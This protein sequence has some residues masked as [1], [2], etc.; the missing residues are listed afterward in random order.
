MTEFK[1]RPDVDGLRAVAVMLVLLFHG[2]LGVSGGFV[3]VDVFFVISGFLITG[4]ILKEQ[5]NGA[6]RI[7]QFWMRRIRRILPASMMIVGATLIA[8]YFILLPD[9]FEE[10]GKSA[11]AQQL[12]L[13]NVFFWRTTSYFGGA[14]E[15]KP[16]LHTWSLAVE[17]QFYLGYPFLLMFLSRFRRR[18]VFLALATLTVG[19][20]AVS[21][22]GSHARPAPT[23][24]L[25]PTRAWELLA[26]GLICFVP[27][28]FKPA[29]RIASTLGL[30]GM[31][32]I[33]YSAFS[34]DHITP[35]PGANALWPCGGA[36]LLIL[37]S[38]SE[39]SL[40]GRLL[41]AR[42]VVFVGLISYSLYLWHW[43]ILVYLKHLSGGE[44][45]GAVTSLLALVASGALATFSLWFIETPFRRRTIF[46]DS[47][48]LLIG[49]FS[50]ATVLMV[51]S[52]SIIAG[53]GAPGRFDAV[54]LSYAAAKYSRSALF[55]V[56]TAMV[57]EGQ[58]PTCG[59]SN[60]QVKCLIWGD[61]HA[62]AF[63]PGLEAACKDCKIQCLQAT[64]SLTP[65]IL[66]FV[67]SPKYG[68]GVH[69]PEFSRAVVEFAKSQKVSLVVLAACW[70]IY[71]D[72]PEFEK[73]LALT[74]QE[75]IAAGMQ[76]VIV[77]EVCDQKCNVPLKLS[78][79]A[80]WHQDVSKFGVPN[81]EHVASV[82]R[83]TEV[84]R[85]LDSV[86]GDH[87]SLLDPTPF[88][89][90][91]TDLWRSEFNGIPMYR[92]DHHLSVEGSLRLQPLFAGA[93]DDLKRQL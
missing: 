69:S 21:A 85:R 3:G 40:V 56:T 24:F 89:V 47:R 91:E 23:F 75:L 30:L 41:A 2:G 27:D 8:G 68:L 88:L 49:T 45:L 18:T 31:G 72:V 38:S 12:M 43:P 44:S 71:A 81:S 14:A 42:P 50:M 9:D 51:A 67:S 84:F 15:L 10:L 90:D 64:H 5:G 26:G 33:L 32:G 62:M 6:F 34:F 29:G 79:A 11:I 48:R 70:S 28:R 66:D 63:V 86:H 76:V 59:D 80:R 36:A 78:I 22:W 35:F 20:F 53:K 74:A 13:S 77:P 7:S 60:S 4:L 54:T 55:E 17:E 82:S 52:A 46:G 65:P 61:S 16:L 19:S 39:L 37:S 58:V 73:K 1:Y 25:L 92:D 57:R 93:M 83:I 87:L